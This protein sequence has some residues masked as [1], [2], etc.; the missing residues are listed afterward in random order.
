MLSAALCIGRAYPLQ[1]RILV[2]DA[3]PVKPAK[4]SLPVQ[5]PQTEQPRGDFRLAEFGGNIALPRLPEKP[6][7]MIVRAPDD[8]DAVFLR[9][10]PAVEC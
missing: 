4:L 7:V 2:L 6:L 1:P 3:E 9:Q 8:A 10:R 5:S